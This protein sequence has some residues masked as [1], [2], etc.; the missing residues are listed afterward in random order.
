MIDP[1]KLLGLSIESSPAEAKASFRDLALIMHPDQGG[2]AADMKVLLDAYRYVAEQLGA[3]NRTGTV[4]GLEAEFAAFCEAQK[5]DEELRPAWVR[6]LLGG[7][8]GGSVS[9]FDVGRF[10]D[11]FSGR[12]REVFRWNGNGE[13]GFGA[14]GRRDAD[15]NPD[16][17]PIGA[18]VG[19]GDLMAPSE[20]ATPD[21]V[22]VEPVEYRPLPA[23]VPPPPD[24]APHTES[25]APSASASPPLGIR[26][27]QRS[28]VVYSQPVALGTLPAHADY[29]DAFNT[30]PE[31]LAEPP[32]ETDEPLQSRLE[33][34]IAE[35][36]LH[37]DRLR[38]DP[39]MGHLATL[40]R[41]TR[42]HAKLDRVSNMSHTRASAYAGCTA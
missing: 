14:D 17:A 20:Y 5:D 1:Y 42:D 32:V 4:E 22:V 27:F 19:Y 40:Q 3:V 39:E 24:H 29:V 28:V 15:A 10:N 30:T 41:M 2:R 37:D 7:M 33:R 26:P 25:T 16:A 23:A 12:H 13:D 6:E 36:A 34:L 21:D 8:S 31:R 11:E 9:G 35:R 38:L 18:D